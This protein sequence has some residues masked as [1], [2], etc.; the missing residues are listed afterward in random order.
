MPRSLSLSFHCWGDVIPFEYP[1]GQ[2]TSAVLSVSSCNHLL[3]PGL[4]AFEG[5]RWGD[6]GE[7][8]SMLCENCWAVAKTLVCYQHLFSYK[9]KAQHYEGSCGESEL[10]PSHTKYNL[11]PLFHS[12]CDMLHSHVIDYISISSSHP[13]VSISYYWNPSYQYFELALHTH[14]IFVP[15]IQIYRFSLSA[16]PCLLTNIILPF[17]GLP[18]LLQMIIT[19]GYDLGPSVKMGAQ[20]RRSSIFSF[21]VSRQHPIKKKKNKLKHLK[22]FE[23][24]SYA[25]SNSSKFR[26]Q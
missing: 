13:I 7:M 2:L 10:H 17:H 20:D 9:H 19:T 14:A 23:P 24:P 21:W 11:Y 15:N 1:F 12:I 5:G 3:T 8:T 26:V 22:H 25:V 18:L 4:L 16:V 6:V